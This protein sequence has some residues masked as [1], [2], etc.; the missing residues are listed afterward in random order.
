MAVRNLWRQP[1][2]S[3]HGHSEKEVP[4]KRPPAKTTRYRHR[5]SGFVKLALRHSAEADLKEI[6]RCVERVLATTSVEGLDRIVSLNDRAWNFDPTVKGAD[7]KSILVDK[8]TV[9]TRRMA[10]RKGEAAGVPFRLR[11]A[12]PTS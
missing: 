9:E 1:G 10:A 5:P 4:P 8:A 7:A 6:A 2:V 3:R 12:F 11:P